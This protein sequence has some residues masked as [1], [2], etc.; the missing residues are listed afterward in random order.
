MTDDEKRAARQVLGKMMLKMLKY[1]TI[2]VPQPLPLIE[3]KA[4]KRLSTDGLISWKFI[5][6]EWEKVSADDKKVIAKLMML[7]SFD[8]AEMFDVEKS[9][10]EDHKDTADYVN[11]H[12]EWG[13]SKDD[14][15]ASMIT[16]DFEDLL[17]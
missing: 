12:P 11:Q 16:E 15:K 10:L 8:L 3:E 6:K 4:A 2:N 5:V 17:G 1:A 13:R 14:V 7:N 9:L